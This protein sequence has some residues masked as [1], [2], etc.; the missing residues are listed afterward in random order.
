[1]E[2]RLD[3]IAGGA[4]QEKA[5]QAF[6]EVIENMLDP[7]TPWNTG[8]ELTIKIKLSQNEAR[9]DLKV[10]ISVNKKLAG[11]RPVDTN[12]YIGKDLDTG[13]V[14]VQEYGPQIRG[15]YSLDDNIMNDM[16]GR[17]NEAVRSD[18]GG[19]VDFQKKR[20]A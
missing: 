15:Q 6:T 11:S 17:K 2:F 20:K 19:I 16:E 5:N 1:M 13:N 10:A 3:E 9:D 18:D 4:V 7:N 14:Y 12:M 8:R